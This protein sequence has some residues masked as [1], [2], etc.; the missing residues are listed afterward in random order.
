[1]DTPVQTPQPAAEPGV[2]PM[3]SSEGAAFM[4]DLMGTMMNQ[5]TQPEP[6]PDNK[7][8]RLLP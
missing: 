6:Q 5:Q 8:I 1:M 3:A 4:Q 2:T 7:C